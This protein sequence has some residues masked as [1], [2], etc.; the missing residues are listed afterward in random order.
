MW[1]EPSAQ[2]TQVRGTGGMFKGS[3]CPVFREAGE[4]LP[5]WHL[6][7]FALLAPPILEGISLLGNERMS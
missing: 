3:L 1:C 7:F 4:A 5:H 6:P 2:S